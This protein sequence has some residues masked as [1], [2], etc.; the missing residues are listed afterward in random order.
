[1]WGRA[2]HPG[3]RA[4]AA[5]R[6]GTAD[7]RERAQR[8]QPGH[9]LRDGTDDPVDVD[10]GTFSGLGDVIEPF[11]DAQQP[12]VQAERN[13]RGPFT[14]DDRGR[15]WFRTIVPRFYPIPDD[16]PVGGLLKPAGRH[17]FRPAHVHLIVAAP[18]YRPVTTHLF[19]AGDP[20]IDSDAVFGVEPSL[21]REFALVDDAARAAEVGLPNPFRCVHFAVTLSAEKI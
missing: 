4:D 16:G 11:Y 10:R 1:V 8:V 7:H 3:G 6:R 21:V 19:V 17:P 20:Y 14:A 12:G 15:F 18:G 2:R 5:G 9:A 13:L